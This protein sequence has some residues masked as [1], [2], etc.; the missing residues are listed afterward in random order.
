M[1]LITFFL[2]FIKT[3]KVQEHDLYWNQIL[4]DFDPEKNPGMNNKKITN[5]EPQGEPVLFLYE[6]GIVV[7]IYFIAILITPGIFLIQIVNTNMYL[8]HFYSK[9]NI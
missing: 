3:E 5:R 8:I 1:V 6:V 2:L 7:L 9:N 4:H